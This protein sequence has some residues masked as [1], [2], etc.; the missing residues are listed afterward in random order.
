M[1]LTETEYHL[2]SE[3][4]GMPD[5]VLAQKA[6]LL[7]FRASHMPDPLVLEAYDTALQ[8]SDGPE[9]FR[10]FLRTYLDG[11]GLEFDVSENGTVGIRGTKPLLDSL[12]EAGKI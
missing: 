5:R 8:M 6:E 1:I 11:C 12:E 10:Q 9:E 7:L 4:I 2:L 3:L